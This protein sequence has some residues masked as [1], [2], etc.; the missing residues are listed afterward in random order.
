ME[1]KIVALSQTVES[2]LAKR[3]KNKKDYLYI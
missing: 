1:H 3:D 2:S